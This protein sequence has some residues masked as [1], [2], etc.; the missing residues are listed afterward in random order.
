MF[1][2]GFCMRLC[3]FQIKFLFLIFNDLFCGVDI[4]QLPYVL[5]C[6]LVVNYSKVCRLFQLHN[7]LNV[8]CIT[9][10]FDVDK[11]N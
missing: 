1:L 10:Y 8:L 7:L 4:N 11:R 5:L 9:L 6:S 2:F 3:Y